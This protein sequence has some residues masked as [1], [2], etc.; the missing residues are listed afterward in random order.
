MQDIQSQSPK[1]AFCCTSI[2]LESEA[3]LKNVSNW[4]NERRYVALDLKSVENPALGTIQ[5][6]VNRPPES[7]YEENCPKNTYSRKNIAFIGASR[8]GAEYI[9]ETDDDNEI[10]DW[11]DL[12]NPDMVFSSVNGS[13]LSQSQNLFAKIYLVEDNIW[14]RGY[15]I[16]LLDDDS[17]A[18][19]A[20]SEARHDVGV[21]QFLVN[22]NPD[23]D[24]IFRLVKGNSVDYKI[25]SSIL[26]VAIAGAYHPFNSQSTLWP[27]V[28]FPLMYLPSTCS[29]RMTDIYRGYVAQHILF[30]RGKCVQ[31]RAPNVYQRRNEHRISSDFFQ[32]YRGY[33]ETQV[34]IEKLSATDVSGLDLD[35]AMMSCYRALLNI[36]VV[37]KEELALLESFLASIA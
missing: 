17:L 30:S 33:S 3:L 4:P 32:E 20:A 37:E 27:R 24:A 2:F 26:P 31:F 6:R 22:G 10:E 16:R 29:F 8:D 23:V 13:T 35:A 15:P 14:A 5:I 28:Y 7:P 1:I 9:Y 11:G 12:L 34:I 19:I 21:V 18:D 25:D 36:G